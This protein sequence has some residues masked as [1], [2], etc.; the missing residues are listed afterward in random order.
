LVEV[1]TPSGSIFVHASL[2]DFTIAIVP[3]SLGA[4]ERLFE[5]GLI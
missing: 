3:V 4:G 5:R 1:L 2:I